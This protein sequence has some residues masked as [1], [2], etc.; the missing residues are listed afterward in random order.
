MT[1]DEQLP[2]A[3]PIEQL[4]QNAASVADALTS[5]TEPLPADLRQRFIDVRTALFQRGIY[6]PVLVRYDSASAP[7]A[8]LKEIGEQLAA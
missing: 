4:R 8:S 6:D 2:I 7:R 3:I 1:H 5:A